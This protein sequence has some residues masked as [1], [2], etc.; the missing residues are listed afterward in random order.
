MNLCLLNTL[1]VGLL[2]S[3]FGMRIFFFFYLQSIQDI[4][5]LRNIHIYITKE[6]SIDE[7]M[8][9]VYILDDKQSSH[10]RD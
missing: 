1:S 7:L 8:A 4:I 5:P 3:L 9:K 6:N 2:T 10:K